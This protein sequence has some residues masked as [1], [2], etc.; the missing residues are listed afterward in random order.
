MNRDEALT[1]LGDQATTVR[2]FSA[3]DHDDTYAEGT[4]IAYS[5]HPMVCLLTAEGERVW[6]RADLAEPV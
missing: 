3:A 6:W 2:A 4:V 5:D 1:V